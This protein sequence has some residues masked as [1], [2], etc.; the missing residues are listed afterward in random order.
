MSEQLLC[1]KN[2][3]EHESILATTAD[4]RIIHAGLL[5]AAAEPGTEIF[6]I[7]DT[8]QLC[9]RGMGGLT[10]EL[11]PGLYKLSYRAGSTI[12]EVYQAIEP[13]AAP[14]HV[15]A[16]MVAYSS[17]APLAGTRA[18]DLKSQQRLS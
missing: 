5:A 15:S 10:A 18:S 4:A 7:D 3:K 12:S 6:V 9:A 16:P 1:R 14:V 11:E 13:G 17:A 2:T 8:F